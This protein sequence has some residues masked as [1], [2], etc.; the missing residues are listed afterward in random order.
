MSGEALSRDLPD[1]LLRRVS[2]TAAFQEKVEAI[3]RQYGIPIDGFIDKEEAGRW[4]CGDGRSPDQRFNFD[5]EIE[6]TIIEYG[7]PLGSA[8]LLE[9][10]VMANDRFSFVPLTPD[11]YNCEFE[12]LQP[13]GFS[14][15][16]TPLEGKWKK[17]NRAFVR[18]YIPDNASLA[19][20]ESY[21][22]QHW[23]YIRE[24]VFSRGQ[25]Q[26]TVRRTRTKVRNDLIEHYYNKSRKE[27]ELKRGEFKDIRVS[28]ILRLKHGISVTPENIRAV[29]HRRRKP[30]DS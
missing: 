15:R 16:A 2:S 17:A 30:R 8:F 12:E 14:D 13:D 11:F 22:E 4:W 24:H 26:K 19:S 3:R 28:S 10:Y 23:R 29:M 6:A 18:L 7:L 5:D 21:L 25:G 1:E 27:L 9:A 20:V